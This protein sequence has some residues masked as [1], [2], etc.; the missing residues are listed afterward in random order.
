LTGL[1]V[2]SLLDHY[3]WTLAPGRLMLG[4]MIGL[5]VGQGIDHDA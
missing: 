2:I 3:F 5:F 1:G 4:L